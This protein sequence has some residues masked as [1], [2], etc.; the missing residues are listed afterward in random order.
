MPGSPNVTTTCGPQWVSGARTT[1]LSAATILML[2][3]IPVLVSPAPSAV[4]EQSSAGSAPADAVQA[5]SPSA[6]AAT[7]APQQ[8]SKSLVW[9][10]FSEE[11]FTVAQR[12]KA[13]FVLSFSSKWCEPCEKMKTNTYTAAAVVEAAAGMPLLS[14]DMTKR[15][16]YLRLV[17]KSFDVFGA[18]TTI[19][20]G[21]D[22]KERE[23]HIGFISPDDYARL[24][25]DSW[26]PKDP[27]NKTSS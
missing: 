17:L 25:R 7:V 15:D 19:F 21:P 5:P 8:A 18:P 14:V 23:R 16:R 20:F 9:T 6:D 24:L 26:K 3:V 11:T 4:A 1:C 22:G 13:P 2:A 12:S 10:P 27:G